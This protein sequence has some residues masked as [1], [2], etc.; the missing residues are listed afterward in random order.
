MIYWIKQMIDLVAKPL[1]LLLMVLSAFGC[2][3]K[4]EEAKNPPDL[5]FLVRT[6]KIDRTTES[7]QHRFSGY[8][9]PWEARGVG[10]MVA[11]RIKSL[12]VDKGDRVKKGQLLATLEDK[13]YALMGRLAEIQVNAL[14]PNYQRVDG[15]VQENVLPKSQLDEFKGKYEAAKTQQEQAKRQVGYTKL[16]APGDGVVMER[17]TSIGQVIGAG[18]PA[19]ILLELDRVKVNFGVTQKDLGYFTIGQKVDLSIPGLER[20]KPGTVYQIDIVPDPKTR[21][22]QV[23][24]EVDNLDRKLRPGMLAHLNLITKEQTGI[25]VPLLSVKRKNESTKVVYLVDPKT[26]QVVEQV[27][28]LGELFSDKVE[29]RSGLQEGMALIV[30][31]QS[32][33]STGD[34]VR[35]K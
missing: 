33:I 20:T 14:A 30:E 10:F 28:E 16:R 6:Q 19:V 9:H 24:V 21:T 32:F 23:I 17:K 2:S 22:Y 18:S 27:V 35:I 3:S 1:V 5:S 8:V 34:R 15:L 11:G 12:R 4:A 31:G 7:R 13:D 25:F 29:I 26:N